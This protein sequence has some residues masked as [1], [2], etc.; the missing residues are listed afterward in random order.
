MMASCC[1]R[2]AQKQPLPWQ[3]PA[4]VPAGGALRRGQ[5][6][7]TDSVPKGAEGQGLRAAL[8]HRATPAVLAAWLGHLLLRKKRSQEGSRTRHATS[9]RSAEG[10]SPREAGLSPRIPVTQPRGSKERAPTAPAAAGLSWLRVAGT[11]LGDGGS[12]Q[13]TGRGEDHI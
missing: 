9:R 2:V 7:D 8:L 11:W 12:T 1:F 3:E 6:C 4:D 10:L 13:Q 5:W